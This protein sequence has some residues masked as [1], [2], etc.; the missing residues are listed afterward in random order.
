MRARLRH[1]RHRAGDP[2]NRRLYQALRYAAHGWPVFPVRPG[3]KTPA[4]PTAHPEGGTPC[5]GECGRTGHGLHDATTDERQIVHWW[6]GHP[7]RN[8]G[9]ATGAPG[10]DV[11]DVDTKGERGNGYAA[12]NEA[13]RAGLTGTPR[14]I[15][16]TPS[17]GMHA[18]YHGTQQRNGT[19][20]D[21]G[22]DYRAQGGYVVAVPSLTG[23]GSYRLVQRQ[24]SAD[25]CDFGAIRDLL[26]P[27]PEIV[28]PFVPAAGQAG[29][30][31]HLPGWVAS[32]REGDRRNDNAFWAMCRAVERGDDATLQ[33]I[34]AAA[35]S[36][37]LT[38]HEVRASMRSARTTAGRPFQP[39]AG[40]EAAS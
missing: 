10:P 24:P 18:Y 3:G 14:A 29:D 33:Q 27:Q 17:G 1:V 35:V 11:L 37:G 5:T 19:L 22:L 34:A 7:D 15:I 36:T 28:R 30:I 9:I 8:I 25:V 38:E 40:R 32:L 20:K 4:L 2:V 6:Q 21:H 31:S 13:K 26:E 39:A 23:D 16:T 12:W